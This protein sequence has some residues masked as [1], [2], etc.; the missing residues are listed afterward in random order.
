MQCFSEKRARASYLDQKTILLPYFG[1]RKE[2]NHPFI[3]RSSSVVPSFI[4][5]LNI[6]KV[7][8]DYAWS[9]VYTS[10]KE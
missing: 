7:K 4:L 6:I 10:D 9:N 5:R 8:K 3:L 2:V 1:G